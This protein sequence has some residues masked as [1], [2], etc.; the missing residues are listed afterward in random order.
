MTYV[1]GFDVGGTRLKSAAVTPDGELHHTGFDSTRCD[2]AEVLGRLEDR[3]AELLEAAGGGC[4]GIGIAVPG[5]T[6]SEFG[7][8]RLP[9]KLLGLEG[10]PLVEHLERRFGLPVRCIPDG[11]AAVL[12]EAVHGAAAG[13]G[14]VVGFTLGTGVGSG[15]VMGGRPLRSEHLGAGMQLGHLTIR[16]DGPTCLCGSRGCAET[17]VSADA[18]AARLHEHLERGVACIWRDEDPGALGFPAV[19]EGA[20]RGDRI[21]G[22]ILDDFRRD[23]GAL[24]VSAVHAFYPSIVVIGGGAVEAAD[25]F[26]PAVQAFVDRHV[27]VYPAQ[28]RVPVVAARLGSRA[29]VLGAAL[30]LAQS[31][32][33]EPAA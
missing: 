8:R 27:F 5:L 1:L 30:H 4:A 10:F 28:R 15:V 23:L 20:A 14:D 33:L 3:A 12:A 24:V 29:G 6:E 26:L 7:V 13:H 25:A 19:I 21:C 11:G 32:E 18:V 22:E 16:S 17:L 31:I 9:G 2:F